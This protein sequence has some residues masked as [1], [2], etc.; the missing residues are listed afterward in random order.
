MSRVIT[1]AAT[2]QKDRQTGAVPLY[3]LEVQFGGSVGTKYYSDQEYSGFPVTVDP[4]VNEWGTI[5]SSAEYGR[6]GG[7][8]SVTVKLFDPDHELKGYFDTKPGIQNKTAYIHLW[9][10]GTLWSDKVTIHGGFVTVPA[11]WDEKSYCWSLGIHGFEEKFDKT[12]GI[13][14]SRSI[15]PEIQCNECEGNIPIVYGDPVYRIPGCAIDRPGFSTLAAQLFIVADD[16]YIQQNATDAGFPVDTPI[17]L[18]VGANGQF[19]TIEGS[20]SDSGDRTHFVISGRSQIQADGISPGSY[21]IGGFSFITIDKDDIS[22]YTTSRAGF[23]LYL[24]QSGVWYQTMMSHWTIS[25]DL[26]AVAYEGGFNVD[27]GNS[28]WKIPSSPGPSQWLAGT[29]VYQV[30]NWK[31]VINFLPSKEI[32]AVEAKAADDRWLTYNP[33]YYSVDYDDRAYNTALGRT[34]G[35]P[36][37]TTITINHAP[38]EFGM[39][40][41]KIYVTL[42]GCTRDDTNSGITLY[43]GPDVIKHL[44]ESDWLGAVPDA[45]VNALLFADATAGTSTSMSFALTENKTLHAVCG[46][47]AF[48]CGCLYFLDAGVVHLRLLETTLSS[49]DSVYTISNDNCS[50]ESLRIEEVST[51]DLPTVATGKFRAWGMSDAKIQRVSTDGIAA[52]NRKSADYDLWAYQFPTSVALTTEFWLAHRLSIQ[53]LVTVETYLPALHVQPG[54]TITIQLTDGAGVDLVNSLARVRSTALTMGGGKDAK[55]PKIKITAEVTLYTF[56]ITTEVPSDNPCFQFNV[57]GLAN[58]V[59]GDNPSF[60][61]PVSPPANSTTTSTTSSTTSSTTT[62][63]TTTAPS[64]LCSTSNQYTLTLSGLSGAGLCCSWMNDTFTL[65]YYGTPCIWRY[66]T[67]SAICLGPTSGRIEFRPTSGTA[68]LKFYVGTVAATYEST[69]VDCN[70]SSVFSLVSSPQCTGWPSTITVTKV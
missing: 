56:S 5:Q 34:S 3:V 17:T 48:Q 67:P 15:F 43:K 47:L 25:G 63:T 4:R 46:E 31:Y 70:G 53:R 55:C 9:F 37:L 7:Y 20:F 2:T 14:L 51:R 42:R 68:T 35:D 38:I 64:C 26:I 21:G 11:S 30:G 28:A 57:V 45:N 19:E 65:D 16:L 32:V 66:D 52:Y 10:A 62:S 58:Q 13:P 33:V 18:V 27:D 61:P 1:A 69:S 49:G 22:N 50:R 59:G 54:D 44:L 40:D 24:S 39:S 23:P 36:G 41:N 8:G 60:T 12:L 6:V 29:P